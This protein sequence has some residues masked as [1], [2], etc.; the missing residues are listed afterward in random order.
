MVKKICWLEST[1]IENNLE[2]TETY[3]AAHQAPAYC[4]NSSNE[5]F[6]PFEMMNFGQITL[7]RCHTQGSGHLNDCKR[8][9]RLV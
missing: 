6:E 2:A 1:K 4:P 9:N 7:Y 3:F 5:Q 8:T